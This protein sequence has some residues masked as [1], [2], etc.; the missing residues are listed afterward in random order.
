MPFSYQIASELSLDYP[1]NLGPGE[2]APFICGMLGAKEYVNPV[3]GKYLFDTSEFEEHGISLYLSEFLE[4][5]YLTKPYVYEPNLSILDVMMWNSPT[6]IV[7]AIKQ[8]TTL[9]QLTDA[10]QVA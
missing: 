8:G 10:K 3:A 5:K 7:S 1:P 2:W 9:I 6:D 4:F